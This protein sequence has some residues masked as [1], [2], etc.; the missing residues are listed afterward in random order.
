MDIA[1]LLFRQNAVMFVYLL[2]GYFLYRRHLITA[3][4]S[5]DIG[6]MLLYIIMPAAIVRSYMKAYSAEMLAGFAVSFLAAL[7]ALALAVAVSSL[8]F[9]KKSA[10]RQF[11]AAF[12]NAGFIGIPLVQMTLGEE[13]VFYVASFVAVLNILQWTFG[14][15]IMTKDRSTVSLKKIVSNPIVISLLIGLLLFFFPIQI[16]EM[17]EGIIGTLAS[18]N[19]PLAMIVLGVYLAQISFREL[20]TDRLA[21]LCTAVRLIVIPIITMIGLLLVPETYETI[22]LAILLAAAAPVGANVAIFAQLYHKEYTDAVKDVCLSTV[23]SIMT[24]PLV[25]GLANAVW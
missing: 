10:I 25:I 13:A 9:H 8:V 4:G 19:G 11:G 20:F 21:Y 6:K 23:F 3:Q 12:S 1:V 17:A 22:R 24:M 18:M 14:V 15:L 16:P 2:I 7:G 5:G